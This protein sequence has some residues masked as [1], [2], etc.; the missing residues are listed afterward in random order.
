MIT[1]FTLFT[2]CACSQVVRL[3]DGVAASSMLQAHKNR[4][5]DQELV[6]LAK[7]LAVIA[8]LADLSGLR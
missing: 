1:I 5:T 7:Y 4:G 6:G 8:K 3:T 2:L